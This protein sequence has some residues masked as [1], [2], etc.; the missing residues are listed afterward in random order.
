V[1][2]PGDHFIEFDVPGQGNASANNINNAGVITGA[3]ADSN[4]ANHGFVRAP[5]GKITTFDPPYAGT[6]PGQGTIPQ[7]INAAGAISGLY[8]DSNN[9]N[10]GFLRLPTPRAIFP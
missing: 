4:K 8:S 9:V 6:G 2:Y 7:S 5:D 10:H 1:R 3:Y